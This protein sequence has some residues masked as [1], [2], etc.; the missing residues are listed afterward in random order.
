MINNWNCQIDCHDRPKPLTWIVN[1]CQVNSLAIYDRQVSG[2]DGRL[3][4]TLYHNYE[5]GVMYVTVVLYGHKYEW[6]DHLQTW[7]QVYFV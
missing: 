3:P 6:W 2:I 5:F 7:L 4:P 1:L